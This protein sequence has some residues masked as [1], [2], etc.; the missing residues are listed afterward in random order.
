MN[1]AKRAWGSAAD[2]G[3]AA[4][5]GGAVPTPSDARPGSGPW[6][7]HSR[8]GAGGPA[9]TTVTG[10]GGTYAP[11]PAKDGLAATPAAGRVAPAAAAVP[12]G[13]YEGV[14]LPVRPAPPAAQAGP[15][16]TDASSS[17][18]RMAAS[19]SSASAAAAPFATSTCAVTVAG[20]RPRQLRIGV[21]MCGLD[22][23]LAVDDCS[24]RCGA[25]VVEHVGHG[26]WRVRHRAMGRQALWIGAAAAENRRLPATEASSSPQDG[27]DR[28]PYG[29]SAEHDPQTIDCA[30]I[31]HLVCSHPT[32][33][34]SRRMVRVTEGEQP[35]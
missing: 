17:S 10:I 18:S 2:A 1:S 23:E 20:R 22:G 19:S 15:P 11:G 14:R 28:R 34:A 21:P 32:R 33:P 27:H 24:T 31:H 12:R 6:P 5:L 9:G 13:M 29:T 16:V 26:G 25:R 30:V 4:V 8:A 35:S 3:D 7:A